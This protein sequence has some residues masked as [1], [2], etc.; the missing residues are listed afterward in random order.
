MRHE[1][2]PSVRLPPALLSSLDTPQVRQGSF[3]SARRM[4]NHALG[5][6]GGGPRGSYRRVESDR[7]P[8]DEARVM[9]MLEER[10]SA[11]AQ[12]DY[13]RADRLRNE[14]RTRFGARIV[15]GLWPQAETRA[16]SAVPLVWC[17]PQ[18]HLLPGLDP[19][20]PF[21]L[22]WRLPIA[23][24]RLRCGIWQPPG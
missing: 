19:Q 2:L 11:R 6:G 14:L 17:R 23:A 7:L 1:L 16:S 13:G 12:R 24:Q 20:Q 9:G 10:I 8:V 18:K 4:V 22:L 3:V 21:P 15:D 5:G